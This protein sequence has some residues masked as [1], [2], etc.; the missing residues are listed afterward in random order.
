MLLYTEKQLDRAYQIDCKARTRNNTPW[1][2]REEF[3]DIYEDLMEIYMLQLDKHHALD[4]DAPDFI[5]DSLNE[6]IGQ[7]LHFEPED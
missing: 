5:L 1:V 7:S 3:R 6:I 4:P 2:K